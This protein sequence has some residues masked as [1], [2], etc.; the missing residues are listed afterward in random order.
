[1]TYWDGEFSF[2]WDTRFFLYKQHFHKQRR[3]EIAKNEA[4]AK[5]HPEAGLLLFI[6]IFHQHY[7]PKIIGHILKNNQKNKCVCFHEIMQLLI[8]KMKMGLDMDRNIVNIN[9]I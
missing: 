5:Q 7:H 6:H 9:N 8:M 4:N 1:M 3:A 2:S